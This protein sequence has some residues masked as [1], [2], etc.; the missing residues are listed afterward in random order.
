MNNDV[1]IVV[2]K[3][4]QS[5]QGVCKCVYIRQG[6]CTTPD[7]TSVCTLKCTCA[8]ILYNIKW[9]TVVCEL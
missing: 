6:V 2:D 8:E 7:K 3:C 5:R 4:V 9:D 1:W